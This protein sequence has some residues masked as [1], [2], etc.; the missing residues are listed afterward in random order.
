MDTEI[1]VKFLDVNKE[2]LR[3]KLKEEGGIL[4]YEERL[5][6]R[7]NYDFPDGRLEKDGGW[8]RIRDEGDSIALSFKQLLRRDVN[9][10]KEVMVTVDSFNNACKL[11]ECIGLVLKSYQETMREKWMMGETEVTIDT[12]PWI[13]SFVEVEGDTSAEIEE[14]SRKLGFDFSSGLYGSVEIVY[15]NYYDVTEKEIDD[16]EEI[17]FDNPPKWLE[18]R[19]IR[20]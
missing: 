6:K 1:E 7:K 13:P 17:K 14:V 11:M 5:M 19:A 3:N 12:W 9:G 4:V 10:T 18:K 16:L 8:V 20:K 15:Q 2:A